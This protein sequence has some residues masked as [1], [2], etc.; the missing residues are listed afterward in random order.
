MLFR[1]VLLGQLHI[2]QT[3]LAKHI[4]GCTISIIVALAQFTITWGDSSWVGQ[5]PLVIRRRRSEMAEAAEKA[6]H[7]PQY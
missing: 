5:A 1:S 4:G 6:Q 7:D 3:A 2:D